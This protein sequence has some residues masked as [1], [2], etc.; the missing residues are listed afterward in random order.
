MKPREKLRGKYIEF[1]ELAN[2]RKKIVKTGK[3][4]V[5]TAGAWD[6]LHVGHMRY[7]SEAKEH[8]DLLVVGVQSDE[9]IKKLKGPNKPVLD[10][11]IRAEALA[12]LDCVDYIVINP[13]RTNITV[14][15][16]LKPD[17]F[18]TVGEDWAR[19]YKESKE[20]KLV[21]EYGGKFNVVERQSPFISTTSIIERI[22]SGEMGTI[23]EKYN[24]KTKPIRERVK[25][26]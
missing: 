14:I 13:F 15:E 12:F 24:K 7:L 22:I 20:Y 16:L 8:A 18:I 23:F 2:F 5:Y 17:V 1:D 25:K 4:I 19:D 11:W 9:A 10:E 21:S 26:S 6:L 3:K